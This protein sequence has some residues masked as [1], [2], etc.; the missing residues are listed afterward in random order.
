MAVRRLT[1]I[2]KP[3]EVV[4]DGHVVVAEEGEPVAM[5]LLCGGHP[6]LGRS[7]KYH[8][9]RSA[10]CFEAKCDGCLMRVDGVP[11]VMTCFEPAR[12]GM[13]LETQNVLGTA[14]TDLLAATDWFFPKGIDHHH[15]F[16]RFGPVN[17]MMQKVA[18][19]IAGIGKLPKV[20]GEAEAPEEWTADVL[21]VGAGVTGLRTAALLAADGWTVRA[22]ETDEKPGGTARF[23]GEKG[24]PAGALAGPE[25]AAARAE[26]AG[27]VLHLRTTAVG[28]YGGIVLGLRETG[29]GTKSVR[30]TARSL[31]LATGTHE[32]G[33]AVRGNDLPGV[34][35]VR[36]AA[37]LLSAGV[38]PGSAPLLV[39]E[40]AEVDALAR[41]FEDKGLSLAGRCAR[42]DLIE[43]Q[44]GHHVTGA[45]IVSDGR[46]V[47]VRTDAVLLQ[48]VVGGAYELGAQAG[49]DTVFG[50]EGFFLR[51]A[52]TDYPTGGLTQGQ[53][54]AWSVGT[55]TGVQS[56]EECLASADR[57]AHAVGSYLRSATPGSGGDA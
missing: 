22:L 45:R 36:A 34:F 16:T 24:G 31:V 12:A 14:D 2:Q 11:N 21:V 41:R 10:K 19:R 53:T 25:D 33:W 1:S 3:I 42:V 56:P 26:G 18:R 15:M 5:S 54:P 29:R 35:G 43:I 50:G 7:V 9:P 6:I 55:C 38:V 51:E 4:V 49:L 39:G 57:V 47:A 32:A 8:R 30:I 40:G 48:G 20:I 37:R 27:V 13:Q 28:V 52:P 17:R 23:L 46:E 44:G